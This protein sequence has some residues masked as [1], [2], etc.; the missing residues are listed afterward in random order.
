MDATTTPAAAAVARRR[1]AQPN[2]WW[3]AALFVAT[4]AALFGS[5]LGTYFYLRFKT[6]VWPP[7][8]IEPPDVVV[9]LCLTAA[10][11]AT[12]IPL[13]LAVRAARAS[14][15]TATRALVLLAVLIQA[16]YIAVQVILFQEDLGKFSPRD[17][18]YASIYFTMLGAHHAHVIFGIL[19][20][21]GLLVKLIGGLTNYRLIGVRAVVLYWYLVNGLAVLVVLTQLSPAL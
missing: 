5:I 12:T 13:L 19:L 9:P 8:G 11:V 20:E 18:A 21:L 4:E 16:G 14:N 6:A 3:G 15:A 10:L 7:Q 2:G 17:T 1:G